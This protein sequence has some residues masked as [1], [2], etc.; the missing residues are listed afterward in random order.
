MGSAGFFVIPA[1]SGYIVTMAK[2]D[3]ES[4]S[5]SLGY[6]PSLDG[7]RGLSILGVMAYHSGLISG[8][9]LGVDVFFVLSGFLITTLLVE[10]HQRQG[11]VSF[12]RFYMRR[13]LR[14]LP[15]LF[16]TVGICASAELA[17]ASPEASQHTWGA[18]AAVVLYVANWAMIAG[19]PLFVLGHTWSLAIEEQFYFVWP[20]SLVLLT[21]VVRR[22]GWILA[23][24]AVGGVLVPAY[25]ILLM[26]R[27]ASLLHLYV[28]LD[29]RADSLLI[30]CA[31]GLLIGWKMLTPSPRFRVASRIAAIAATLTLAYLFVEATWPKDYLFHATSTITSIATALLIVKL[32]MAPSKFDCVLEGSPLV[33]L[34]RI[35]Y[36]LYLWHYPIF[37]VFGALN[38]PG[39]FPSP[40]RIPA[41]WLATLVI[42]TA[43][44]LVLERP[45]LRLKRHFS[46]S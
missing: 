4:T 27:G 6:R 1:E 5:A 31:V 22:R 38:V 36:G 13:A 16:A 39:V 41:A 23:M 33:G 40:S 9:Y 45:V 14:L 7:L 29:A 11:R 32:F 3:A 30:G 42:A 26:S 44:F 46:A 37:Y 19:H 17:F 18:V 28:G 8:G 12:R 20:P 34:G 15:A 21:R 25:R 10:E 35:S 43:S 2:L 24:V